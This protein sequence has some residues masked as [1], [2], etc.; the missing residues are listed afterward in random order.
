[1]Q[2]HFLLIVDI[3][4]WVSQ[5]LFPCWFSHQPS[6]ERIECY[7]DVPSYLFYTVGIMSFTFLPGQS[8]DRLRKRW[9]LKTIERI[10]FVRPASCVSLSRFWRRTKKVV[11][12]FHSGTHKRKRCDTQIWVWSVEFIRRKKETNVLPPVL[13]NSKVICTIRQRRKV[14]W[15]AASIAKR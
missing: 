6:K 1:V 5:Q 9:R 7:F 14:L 11:V 4:F 12:I 13:R 3:P 15:C 8:A 10:F 2:I